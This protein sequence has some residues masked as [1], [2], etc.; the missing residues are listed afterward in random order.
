M[1]DKKTTSQLQA[2]LDTILAWFESDKID[3]DAAVKMYEEGLKLI[4]QLQE[5][6]NTAENTIKKVT[7]SA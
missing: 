1:T 5:R 7:K 3:I 6:L 2:E 4:E